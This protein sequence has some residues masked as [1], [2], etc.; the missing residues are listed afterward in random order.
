MVTIAVNPYLDR[1]FAPIREEITTD[2]LPVIGE[3]PLDLS[4]CLCRILFFP[5]PPS[6]VNYADCSI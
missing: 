4:G 5:I 6:V 1:N 2:K 3:L